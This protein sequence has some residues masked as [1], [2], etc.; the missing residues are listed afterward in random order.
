MEDQGV[1]DKQISIFLGHEP[2]PASVSP[3]ATARPIRI[4]P[5]ICA[6]PPRRS[7]A[8]CARSTRVAASG[9]C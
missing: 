6:R 3:A 2:G 8:S 7:S 5:I 1:P 4:T 9:I